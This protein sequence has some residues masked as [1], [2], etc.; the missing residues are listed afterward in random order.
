M[1]SMWIMHIAFSGRVKVV[2][3]SWTAKITSS[4]SKLLE[5]GNEILRCRQET[6]KGCA[7]RW[8]EMSATV[9]ILQCF[10]RCWRSTQ[11]QW[12]LI[13]TKCYAQYHIRHDVVIKFWNMKFSNFGVIRQSYL[14]GIL[15]YDTKFKNYSYLCFTANCGS[16]PDTSGLQGLRNKSSCYCRIYC[17]F[18]YRSTKMFN[19]SNN[20]PNKR[21]SNIGKLRWHSIFDIF[22]IS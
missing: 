21:S 12:F 17:P 9:K 15:W 1:S 22:S 18:L 7:P 13:I 14:S 3:A 2:S 8:D 20:A 6:D 4:D 19:C 16:V 10:C 11:D 5:V